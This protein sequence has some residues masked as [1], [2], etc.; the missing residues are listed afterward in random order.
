MGWN[1]IVRSKGYKNFMAKLYGIGASVVIIGAL[2]KI[3]HYPGASIMLLAGMGTEAIIFMFSAFEPLHVEF[4]W[5]LVY[6]ELL[7]GEDAAEL[8]TPK[9][10]RGARGANNAGSGVTQQLD[11]ML[12]DSKIDSE[13]IESLASGMRN[14]SENANKLSSVADATVATDAYISNLA[15]AANSVKNLSDSYDKTSAA[16]NKDSNISAEYL[17]NVQK[18]ASAVG[19]LANIYQETIKS[20]QTDNGSYNAE[21]QKMSKNLSAINAMYELQLQSS[22]EHM[23]A[24]QNMEN[25]IQK[26]TANLKET[27]ANTEKYKEQVDMLTKN[28]SQLNTIYGNMLTAMGGNRA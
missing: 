20:L 26:F 16:L 25:D 24:T 12:E 7:M 23:T 3:M 15:N 1:E 18:A 9:T 22:K 14:L 10:E 19:G 17:N 11:K 5:G 27:V 6:P 4:N 8:G 13:L 21:L 28:V 2:F